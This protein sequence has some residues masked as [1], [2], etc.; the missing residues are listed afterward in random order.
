M[1]II[2][3]NE[4]NLNSEDYYIELIDKI[5]ENNNNNLRNLIIIETKSG[6]YKPE[7]S[8]ILSSRIIFKKNLNSLNNL[9]KNNKEVIKVNFSNFN[10]S[11]VGSMKSTFSGCSNLEEVNFEGINTNKLTKMENTFENCTNIKKLDLSPLNTTN[12]KEWIIY[13]LVVID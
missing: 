7:F 2:N 10:M 5:T 12:L 4:I 6:I 1:S 3:Q 13:F 9:F 8:G 11:E